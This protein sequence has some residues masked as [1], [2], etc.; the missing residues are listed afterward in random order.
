MQFNLYKSKNN[1]LSS[2]TLRNPETKLIKGE[3]GILSYLLKKVQFNLK[4]GER[5]KML[6]KTLR[7]P[8]IF[9]IKR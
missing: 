6:T 9:E 3:E 2:N 7:N 1:K 4:K 5:N 8:E